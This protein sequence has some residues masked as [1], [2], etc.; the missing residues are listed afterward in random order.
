MAV[1]GDL[2]PKL[3]GGQEGHGAPPGYF[4]VLAPVLLFPA[5]LLAPA[6]AVA[7]LARPRGAGHP[8]RALLAHP[9]LAGLRARA[10]QAAAL[11]AALLRR[12]RLAAGG[13]ADAAHGQCVALA[14]RGAEPRRRGRLRHRRRGRR[15]ALRRRGELVLGG[16]GGAAVRRRRRDRRALPGAAA[17]GAGGRARR[18][19]RRAGPQHAGRRRR[20]DAGQSVALQARR[21]RPGAGESATASRRDHPPSPATRSRAWSSRS[22]RPPSS[23]TPTPPPRPSTRVAPRW[24]PAAP[25]RR[26][27]AAIAQGAVSAR[28]DAVEAGLDY[29]TGHAQVLRL[30][31]PMPAAPAAPAPKG[32]SQASGPP[33]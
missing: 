1:G 13:G 14:R 32:Q 26:F 8:L 30:Y 16:A 12:D 25:T 15:L 27:R 33:P 5:V 7:G 9:Q 19:L 4:L 23:A 22:A 17:A 20:A 24:W 18:R 3:L 28:V 29:S 10:D 11:H 6:A 31:E 21:R 2:A